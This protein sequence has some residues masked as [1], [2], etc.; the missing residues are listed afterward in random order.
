[1]PTAEEFVAHAR[2]CYQD[3]DRAQA[4]RLCWEGLR[5]SPL[6][7]DA[8]YLLG[9]IA[10]ETG[11]PV[12]ALLHLHHAA[13]LRPGDAAF[14]H[15]LG[16]AYRA[17]GRPA[18]AAARFHEALRL[19]PSLGAAHH[20]LGL[21]LLDQGDVTGAIASFR[22]AVALR[23]ESE[24]FHLNLGRALQTQGDVEG[25]A[26]CYTE[27]V[28][29]N[30]RYALAHNN[31]GVALQ[32]QGRHAEALDRF[33]QALE[34]HAE[35][36]E[37]HLNRASSLLAIG[38]ARAARD[39]YQEAIR[40]RAGYAKAHLGLARALEALGELPAA[41]AGYREAVRLQPDSVEAY[42]ALGNLLLVQPDWEG[43]RAAFERSLALAP[44][45]PEAFARL[46]YTRQMLCDWRTL[47][48][49]LVR[50]ERDTASALEQGKPS[51][52]V[53]FCALTLPWTAERQRAIA[54][55]HSEATERQAVSRRAAL[56]L[57]LPEPGPPAGGRLR[58]GYLSGE[59]RDHAVAHLT[60]G[61]FGLHD[62]R[63]FEIFAYSYGSDD[64]STYRRRIARDCD[65]FVD[66]DPLSVPEAARR[67]AAD[68]IHVLVDLQGYAGFS[69]N[70][71]LALRPAPVQAHYLGYPGT[72]A[73]A[74]TD[75]LV[76]DAVVTPPE[77]WPAFGEAVA[78]LPDCYL[79]TDRE[80]PIS[81]RPVARAEHGLP[82]AGAVFC[83]FNNRYKLEPRLWGVW[84]RILEQVPGSVLWLSPGGPV[85]EENLRREA[86]ARGVAPERLVFARH[87]PGKPEHLARHRAA[88][89][90]LDTLYYNGHTTACDALWAGLPVLTCPGG[91]FAARVGASLLTSVGL[92]ELIVPD[93]EAYERRAVH[94]ARHPDE[95]H[96][97]REKLAAQR[98]TWPLFDTA[99]RVRNLER[100]YRTMW[101]RYSAGEPPVGFRVAEAA[102]G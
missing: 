90:Y 20:A 56:G 94:L 30:P 84:M 17:A 5:L 8:V 28:R 24:R 6:H 70:A 10:L 62:R 13:T 22:Q 77:L 11:R 81:P 42:Q 49:D 91:T 12:Q 4:E 53:P 25:A 48:E 61:L 54:R 85:A 35:Y 1:M 74:F 101:E 19:E 82:A 66:L 38:E 76:G 95:L 80:Q 79:A 69:R 51:P 68:G 50:L 14:Q 23:P 71:L 37:A 26:A 47:D 92:P 59:F 41:L 29:L 73:G 32:A 40:L 9:A 78:V 72:I 88:D 89:L 98:L 15:A 75:Y 46:V 60:Q 3:G 65:H 33:R 100:A 96:G 43:A 58:I 2:Q 102:G 63:G 52:V 45:N 31:L 44:D 67:I 93:L 34:L 83:A 64:G 57:C 16:E 39:E 27:A 18:E 86:R 21:A 87:V 55:S 7:P 99:R 36:P 97:L